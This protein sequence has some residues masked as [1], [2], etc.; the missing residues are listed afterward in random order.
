MRKRFI[1]FCT[2]FLC[3]FFIS[4][5]VVNADV[6]IDKLIISELDATYQTTSNVMTQDLGYGIT[7][8][9]DK[10]LSSAAR[11]NDIASAG[12]KNTLVGQSVNVLSIPSN[13]AVRIVN[14]SY[15]LSDGWTK[16]TVKS[17]AK[18]F[19]LNNPGWKVIAGINGDF[20]DINAKQALPYQGNGVHVTDG[21]VYRPFGT[22]S[23]VG[24]KN[25]GST[26]QL[27]GGADCTVGSL[28][29]AIYDD[30]QIVKE[31]LVDKINEEPINN[32]IGVWYT[33]NEMQKQTIDNIEST[34]RTE[35]PVSVKS[36]TYVVKAPERCLP[37][38]KTQIYGKGQITKNIED[39]TLL[40][41]QFAIETNNSEVTSYLNDNVTVR[42][43]YNITGKFA[44]CDN[45]TGAGAQLVKDGL[46]YEE[47]GGLDRHPRTCVGIKADGSV[48]FFTVDGRQ[49]ESDMYG[50]SYAEL[51]CALLYYGCVE[52]YNLD[53]GGSTT[54]IIRNEYNDFDV[55][56]SPSDGSERSDSN[57]LLVVVPSIQLEASEVT[58]NSAVFNYTISKGASINNLKLFLN[59]EQID[60]TISNN[61]IYLNNLSKQT[62]YNL[63]YTFDLTYK[64]TTLENESNALTFKTGK[65]TPMI[66]SCYLT[67]DENAFHIN[68]SIDDP[69]N[70]ISM[71]FIK[72]GTKLMRVLD[73]TTPYELSKESIPD[74]DNFTPILQYK[75]NINS[76]PGKTIQ[77]QVIILPQTLYNIEYDLDGGYA[78]NPSSY[79][80]DNFIF[81]FS[82][83]IKA[84]YKFIG[85]FTDKENGQLIT[86]L[87]DLSKENVK[88]YAR[89][90]LLSY[91]INYILN[92]STLENQNP[93]SYSINSF[94]SSLNNPV[95]KHY[96]FDGWYTD[97]VGG[98]KIESILDLS[99][100]DI[101]LYARFTPI[102]YQ[103]TYNLDGGLTYNSTTLTV[104]DLPYELSPATKPGYDFKCWTIDGKEVA[105][106]DET[107]LSDLT[108]TANYL[109]KTV[110]SGCGC[111]QNTSI[112]ISLSLILL[113]ALIVLR[114]KH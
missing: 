5:L 114:R 109:N 76:T 45:I 97:K 23:N 90:E 54:M 74:L 8:I 69:D 10:A 78:E 42:I 106:L 67:E 75:Y 71:V 48:V 16:Q 29:L 26:Y 2:L 87:T 92:G 44:E 96:L 21:E 27:V 30:D 39:T 104:E 103:I 18:N 105:K 108:L 38:S 62:T 60:Y 101:T 73:Y 3:F 85:W 95:K 112:F 49:F 77:E 46:A 58:V 41:G 9:K 19:E 56:N 6:E 111:S 82:P 50:M 36:G 94:V 110:K 57:A 89:Y 84:G 20:F 4:I 63:T 40:F 98:E 33:Y 7:H 14:W 25:D 12:P 43:Q 107:N 113:S 28:T 64:N 80:N 13:E 91:S 83:A 61:Q 32:E 72:V 52:A 86:K 22:N 99:L 35:I 34:V 24:F 51:S 93:N 65:T 88:L 15:K 11:L 53:G 66:K 102:V 37:I 79:G 1:Y 68:L 59:N 70:A 55:L 81:E 17:L 47:G 31:F 100:G